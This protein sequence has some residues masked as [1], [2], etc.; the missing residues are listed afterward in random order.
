M[1]DHPTIAPFTTD[2][3]IVIEMYPNGGWV[4]SQSGDARCVS[5]RLGAYGSAKEMLDALTFA[6]APFA[7]EAG[8]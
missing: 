8:Q 7:S 1:R 6:L 3:P 4:V 5:D 2:Q